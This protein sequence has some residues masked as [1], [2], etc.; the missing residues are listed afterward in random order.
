MNTTDKTVARRQAAHT[1]KLLAEGGRRITV[2][3]P[4]DINTALDAEL[5][6]TG[7]SANALILRLLQNYLSKR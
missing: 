7:D 6:E 1:S 2:R 5:A 4:P 3:L